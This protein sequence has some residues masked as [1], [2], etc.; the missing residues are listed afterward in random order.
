MNELAALRLV[1]GVCL[2]T[3][4]V[5]VFLLWKERVF[6]LKEEE[7]I[8]FLMYN[9]MGGSWLLAIFSVCSGCYFV[10]ETL[11]KF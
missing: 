8:H 1:L 2:L 4:G 7:R 11:L 10:F 5:L 3:V 6:K 9:I